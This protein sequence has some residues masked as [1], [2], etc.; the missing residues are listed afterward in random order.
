VDR[1]TPINKLDG[2]GRVTRQHAEE[3]VG[4]EFNAPPDTI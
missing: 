1:P 4:V 2:N 3:E